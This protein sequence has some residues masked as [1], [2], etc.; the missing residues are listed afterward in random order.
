MNK[1]NSRGATVQLYFVLN[2]K[3]NDFMRLFYTHIRFEKIIV[4]I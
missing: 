4:R 3:I 2:S 1:K